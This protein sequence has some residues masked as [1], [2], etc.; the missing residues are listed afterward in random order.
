MD[1][2]ST[3]QFSDVAHKLTVWTP[4]PETARQTI[5]EVMSQW[6]ELPLTTSALFL[7]PRVLQR[8][9]FS[10]SSSIESLGQFLPSELPSPIQLDVEF[11]LPFVLLY[12]APHTRSLPSPR[13][14]S[15]T[16]S[17]R[18]TKWHLKQGDDLRRLYEA[19]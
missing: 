3:W 16:D 19:L 18:Y 8:E 4:Q 15:F 14:E 6:V 11:E 10:L 13:L 9:W 7:V 5:F 17:S 12:L 1:E 2:W